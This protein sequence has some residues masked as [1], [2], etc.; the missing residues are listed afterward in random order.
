VHISINPR[1]FRGKKKESLHNFRN[2]KSVSIAKNRGFNSSRGLACYKDVESLVVDCKHT[3]TDLI[4][5]GMHL[6]VDDIVSVSYCLS[7]KRNCIEII[8][9]DRKQGCELVPNSHPAF[10]SA[11]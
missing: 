8:E 3:G 5:F 1:R 11:L 2:Q 9:M 4:E 7:M 10:T 6:V